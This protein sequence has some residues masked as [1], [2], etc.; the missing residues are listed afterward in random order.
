MLKTESME[1]EIADLQNKSE[2]EPL[3]AAQY[4]LQT[5]EKQTE[6]TG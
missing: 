3:K 2:K 4:G 1:A 6:A 5:P